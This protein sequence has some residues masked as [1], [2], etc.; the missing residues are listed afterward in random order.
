MRPSAFG[1]MTV[2]VVGSGPGVTI[3]PAAPV[4]QR[5]L[6]SKTLA[7]FILGDDPVAVGTPGSSDVF[8]FASP[9]NAIAVFVLAPGQSLYASR[10]AGLAGVLSVH[11]ADAD[12]LFVGP[13]AGWTARDTQVRRV[14]LLQI[15]YGSPA[16]PYPLAKAPP[17]SMMRVLVRNL[18]FPVATVFLSTDSNDLVFT[19]TTLNQYA[20]QPGASVFLLAPGQELFVA[21]IS[22]GTVP[23]T[24][25]TSRGALYGDVYLVQ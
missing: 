12:E 17:D 18:S 2:P 11:S 23:I 16:S 14:N 19:G 9:G 25:Q 4:P 6:V 15:A 21:S 7:T 5:V 1:A 8:R 22:L 3:V 24:V 10:A 13:K 20:L